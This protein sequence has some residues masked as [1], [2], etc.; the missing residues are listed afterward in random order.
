MILELVIDI[1]AKT[2]SKKNKIKTWLVSHLL[3]GCGVR[4]A[5]FGVRAWDVAAER[6]MLSKE[7]TSCLDLDF[8]SHRFPYHLLRSY[9]PRP[10]WIHNSII[11]PLTLQTLLIMIMNYD[12]HHYPQKCLRDFAS[13]AMTRTS[14]RYSFQKVSFNLLLFVIKWQCN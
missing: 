2:A 14:S 8:L 7:D 5:Q 13:T 10:V 3:A 11:N 12:I 1:E 6:N 9:P 4:E